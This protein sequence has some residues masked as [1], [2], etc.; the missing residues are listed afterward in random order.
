M[1]APVV[2]EGR[3]AYRDDQDIRDERDGV[4]FLSRGSGSEGERFILGILCILRILFLRASSAG[5]VEGL[6]PRSS[7]G[8]EGHRME[9]IFR[10]F[11]MGVS[12]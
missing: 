9:R 4:F 6:R 7:C 2:L 1:P 3:Q 12:F 11:R 10:M 8:W 5:L